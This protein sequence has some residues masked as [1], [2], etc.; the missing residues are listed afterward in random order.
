MV[1]GRCHR[2]PMGA[3]AGLAGLPCRNRLSPM[4]RLG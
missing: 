1:S 4:L 2:L 3:T